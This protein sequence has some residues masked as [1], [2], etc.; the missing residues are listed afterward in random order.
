MERLGRRCRI[1]ADMAN[2]QPDALPVAN[3]VGLKEVAEARGVSYSTVRATRLP[4]DSPS[5]RN[6]PD[7]WERALARLARERAGNLSTLAEELESITG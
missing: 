7:G 2:P 3:S 6:P 5:H 4:P 1:I